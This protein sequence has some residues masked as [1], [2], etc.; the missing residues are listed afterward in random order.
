MKKEIKRQNLTPWWRRK[1]I[2]ETWESLARGRDKSQK[3]QREH[4]QTEPSH[5]GRGGG[6]EG[7]DRRGD[8]R[9]SQEAKGTK[10]SGLYREEQPN[11][12]SWRVQ[13]G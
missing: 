13:V 10:R 7:G 2:T 4:D 6:E 8:P 5:V 11:P 3:V 12:L 1:L 9:R